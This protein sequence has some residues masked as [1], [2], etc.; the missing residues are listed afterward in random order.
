MVLHTIVSEYD[1]L[2]TDVPDTP[3]KTPPTMENSVGTT[4]MEGFLTMTRIGKAE[5]PELFAQ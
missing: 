1:V 5:A 4:S 2:R 3:K